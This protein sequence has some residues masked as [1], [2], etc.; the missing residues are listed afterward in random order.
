[1]SLKTLSCA[2][3]GNLRRCLRE[4]EY[5]AHCFSFIR[6]ASKR[7][8]NSAK[9]LQIKCLET[10]IT[11]VHLVTFFCRIDEREASKS[12]C[13]KNAT[14]QKGGQSTAIA[15]G[16]DEG[17]DVLIGL[18]RC[19]SRSTLMMSSHFYIF[20]KNNAGAQSAKC[21]AVHES[22]MGRLKSSLGP[23]HMSNRLGVLLMEVALFTSRGKQFPTNLKTPLNRLVPSASL[24]VG[25]TEVTDGTHKQTSPL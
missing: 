5:E 25:V 6:A 11:C 24:A 17:E 7:G 14:E 15:D 19:G 13:L 22:Q 4:S 12:G 9:V 10:L 20:A 18:A 2:L 8:A 16:N 1:M 21:M 23:Q 3:C